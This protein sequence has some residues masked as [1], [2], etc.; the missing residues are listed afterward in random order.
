MNTIARYIYATENLF[1]DQVNWKVT[2]I[3]QKN[4]DNEKL[5]IRRKLTFGIPNWKCIS[6]LTNLTKY[7]EYRRGLTVYCGLPG[8]RVIHWI[9]ILLDTGYWILDTFAFGDLDTVYAKH[10]WIASKNH[11]S[12]MHLEKLVSGHSLTIL[13]SSMEIWIPRYVWLVIWKL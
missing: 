10:K 3:V 11:F 4:S 7:I 13:S 5:Q 1:S 2:K 8:F 12:L 9:R 6:F